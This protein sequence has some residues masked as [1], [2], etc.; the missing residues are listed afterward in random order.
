MPMESISKFLFKFNFLIITV[1]PHPHL[2]AA[3]HESYI[4]KEAAKKLRHRL[5][6][7]YKNN[8]RHSFD[9]D[10]ATKDYDDLL[11]DILE[12]PKN[13][14]YD[15]KYFDY[16]PAEEAAASSAIQLNQN[17]EYK[18]IDMPMVDIEFEQLMMVDND[19][20]NNDNIKKNNNLDSDD[21]KHTNGINGKHRLKR[22]IPAKSFGIKDDTVQFIEKEK[23]QVG[24]NFVCSIFILPFQIFLY[25][26]NFSFIILLHLSIYLFWMNVV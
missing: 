19:K 14:I 9:N 12:K 20:D 3:Y 4:T 22:D 17:G 11:Q 6:T 23:R 7:Q 10:A 26:R 16:L 5:R 25:I 18:K 15:K 8:H 13:D 2:F 1:I 24:K 21:G